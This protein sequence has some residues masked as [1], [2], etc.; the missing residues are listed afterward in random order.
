[1]M[2][3]RKPLDVSALKSAAHG[4]SAINT[5][6][7]GPIGQSISPEMSSD[8]HTRNVQASRVGK[9]QIAGHFPKEVKRS[10][11]MLQAKT[12]KTTQDLLEEALV[13]LFRKYN[14]PVP[15]GTERTA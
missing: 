2:P 4:Q 5:A 7:P 6:P 12:D 8:A 14:V 13:E 3:I 9:V 11:R 15:F 1:M 10:L